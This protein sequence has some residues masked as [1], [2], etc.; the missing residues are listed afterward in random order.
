MRA[1]YAKPEGGKAI[2]YVGNVPTPTFDG[3][4]KE[5]LDILGVEETVS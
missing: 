3:P 5:V 4:P 1:Y 2:G